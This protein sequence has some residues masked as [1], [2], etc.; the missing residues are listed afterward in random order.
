MKK[1]NLTKLMAVLVVLC[2][3]TSTFVGSTL[4]KYTTSKSAT[5]SARVAKFGVEI[6]ATGVM[7]NDSYKDGATTYS[8]NEEGNAITVQADNPGTKIV[9][10][11]TNGQLAAIAVTGKPEVDVAVTY[12]ADLALT[13][14]EVEGAYYCPIEITVGTETFKGTTYASA[15]EFESAV[16]AAIVAKKADYDTNTDLS[17]VNDDVQVSWAWAFDGNDDVKDT[18]LGD[19]AAD[20]DAANISLKVTTTITQID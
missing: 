19:A 9:A 15:A 17:A 2:L 11:G 16:E 1:M 5:D 10:P 18:A 3:I 13:D 8:A 12:E 20:G 7:F 6:E 14:W 4:A